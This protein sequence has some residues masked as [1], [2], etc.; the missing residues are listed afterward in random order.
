[1][2][3]I[4]R[5]H[6]G[7]CRN[8]RDLD[9][10]L[11]AS[12]E[13]G[14]DGTSRA[15]RHLILTGPN[16]SGKSGILEAIAEELTWGLFEE[17]EIFGA[18]G[19]ARTRLREEL[20]S[21]L[22]EGDRRQNRFLSIANASTTYETE[23]EIFATDWNVDWA[24][25]RR[26]F[27]EGRLIIVYVRPSRR[28]RPTD[29]AG[30]AKLDL[31]SPR[32]LPELDLS[33][34]FQQFL[35]NRKFEQAL[36]ANAGDKATTDRIE[37]WFADFVQHMRWMTDDDKLEMAFRPKDFSFFFRRG[38]GYLFDLNTLADGHAAILALLADILLRVDVAQRARGDLTFEPEG[39]VIIDEV[40]THLHPHLQEQ[41][42]PFLT[43]LFPKL[44]FLVATHSPAVI[45]S[46]SGAVICDLATR[47]QAPSELYRGVPYGV[48]M[49]EHFGLSSDI[50]LESTAWL[51]ELRDL[52][53][54][55]TR[56]P[57]EEAR[58]AELARLL[59][60]RAPALATEVWMIR[61]GIAVGPDA[62]NEKKP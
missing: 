53:R 60:E 7:Q 12:S 41:I 32:I 10:D 2:P 49:M 31:E 20:R 30:P 45:A 21:R 18:I 39:V 33:E 61:K 27:A 11:S 13:N 3:Y 24:Q 50:D 48:L 40:E 22:G 23:E 47:E 57:A 6:V 44:Q 58:F 56:T 16:G 46:I 26:D 5:I 37:R 8:V 34:R 55:P 36:A 43:K 17:D 15:F 51:R 59:S 38:D 19:E 9:I 14:A 29:I 35:V 25:A 28:L 62:P 54:R 1:M 4:Q 42:L 52:G